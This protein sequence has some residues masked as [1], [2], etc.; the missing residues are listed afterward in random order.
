VCETRARKPAPRTDIIL[1]MR[2]LGLICGIAFILS[3]V[4]CS[5]SEPLVVKEHASTG[6][7][8]VQPQGAPNSP[9]PATSNA[10]VPS[11]GVSDADLAT[12][13]ANYEKTKAAYSKDPKAKDAYVTATV[14]YATGTMLADSLGPKE[15]YPGALKLYREALKVDP[16][17][18]EALSNKDL[19][20]GIYKQMGRP[21]PQ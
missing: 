1:L 11:A 18:K 17:N 13:K 19:I 20:E 12:F 2:K 10:P 8:E 16:N 14:K 9:N 21:I 15:K 7:P 3:M 6:S 5:S 4:G